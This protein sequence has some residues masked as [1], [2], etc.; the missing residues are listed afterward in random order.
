[1]TDKELLKECYEWL[2]FINFA[3]TTVSNPDSGFAEGYFDPHK[4]D[5][6][7]DQVWKRLEPEAEQAAQDEL[8]E[9][10]GNEFRKLFAEAIASGGAGTD[11]YTP[12]EIGRCVLIIAAEN[13]GPISKEGKKLLANLRHF[14]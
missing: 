14:I 13:F 2:N 1:M 8:L 7:M 4:L 5:S 12:F 6:V 3:N 9:N 11:K 10:F